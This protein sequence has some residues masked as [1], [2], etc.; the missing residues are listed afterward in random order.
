VHRLM[1]AE[2]KLA[3][4]HTAPAEGVPSLASALVY[5]DR[6]KTIMATIW[7]FGNCTS[8]TGADY[9]A[10]STSRPLLGRIELTRVCGVTWL[11]RESRGSCSGCRE[12]ES[13]SLPIMKSQ[14]GNG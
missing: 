5:I 13:L 12:I 4:R 10:S 7:R 2:H 8:A 11:A 9:L 14:K 1:T 6:L 3:A